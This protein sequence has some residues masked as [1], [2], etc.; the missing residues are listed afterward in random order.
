MQYIKRIW[1]NRQFSS[2]LHGDL[3]PNFLSCVAV[4]HVSPAMGVPRLCALSAPAGYSMFDQNKN[5]Y[6]RKRELHKAPSDL[7]SELTHH[8][9]HT[10]QHKPQVC[11]EVWLHRLCLRLSSHQTSEFC[12]ASLL[13]KHLF[14]NIF[15]VCQLIFCLYIFFVSH[16]YICVFACHFS[17]F[18]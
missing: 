9:H 17:L 6:K 1:K 13:L 14:W 7:V 11:P 4:S 10:M 3:L 2:L 8:F 5:R 18:K 12:W 15:L 16:N